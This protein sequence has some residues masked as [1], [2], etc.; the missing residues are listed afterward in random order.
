[1]MK[2]ETSRCTYHIRR[3]NSVDHLLTITIQIIVRRY[4]WIGARFHQLRQIAERQ[5]CRWNWAEFQIGFGTR[6]VG[7]TRCGHGKEEIIGEGLG[8]LELPIKQFFFHPGE[9]HE[10]VDEVEGMQKKKNV[11]NKTHER[12]DTS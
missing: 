5:R 2:S 10:T 12:Q 4:R 11:S 6:G 7:E 3:W 1:M 9:E 8:G